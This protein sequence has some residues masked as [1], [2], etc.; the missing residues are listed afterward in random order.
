MDIK[1]SPQ[2]VRIIDYPANMRRNLNTACWVIVVYRLIHLSSVWCRIKSQCRS[3]EPA[4]QISLLLPSLS[5]SLIIREWG[6]TISSIQMWPSGWSSSARTT[7]EWY[8]GLCRPVGGST[9]CVSSMGQCIYILNLYLFIR[10]MKTIFTK[11]GIHHSSVLPFWI[12]LELSL[13]TYTQ[14]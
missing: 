2:Q 4:F 13:I 3:G 11:N 10:F 8:D 5:L 9:C 6:G 1:T 14:K 7:S 12:D